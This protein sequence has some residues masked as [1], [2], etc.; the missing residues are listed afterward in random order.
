MTEK[1]NYQFVLK[2]D[3]DTF[4]DILRVYKNLKK[5]NIK[6][7]KLWWWSYFR[8]F[9]YVDKHGKW[10]GDNY[11]S[12][13][14]PPFPCGGGYVINKNIVDYIVRNLELLE[15]FQGED[16][17]LGIWLGGL[18]VIRDRPKKLSGNNVQK[19]ILNKY[20]GRHEYKLLMLRQCPK[21]QTAVDNCQWTCDNKKRS[22]LPFCN[23]VQL[24]IS[25]MY[26]A[27]ENFTSRGFL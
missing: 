15:R 14:Y 2:T 26:E 7:E 19:F 20:Y 18:S 25:G 22:D 11:R 24:N 21:F 4:I 9:W 13:S 1:K 23:K 6:E 17:S 27:W 12:R 10:R 8:E 5:L 3:D 16:V